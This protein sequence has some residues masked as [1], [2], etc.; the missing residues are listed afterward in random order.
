MIE[1]GVVDERGQRTEAIDG[2]LH[3]GGPAR[4]GRDVMLDEQRFTSGGDDL[5][6]DRLP[7]R[8]PDIRHR[9]PGALAREDPRMPRADPP[10]PAAAHRYLAFHPLPPPHPP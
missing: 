6:D 9:D 3:R 4:F 2:L 1:S 8:G 7:S 5:R 10:A